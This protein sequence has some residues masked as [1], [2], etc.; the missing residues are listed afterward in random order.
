MHVFVLHCLIPPH[1]HISLS[2]FHVFLFSSFIFLFFYEKAYLLLNFVCTLKT[3]TIIR[4]FH[5]KFPC[6]FCFNLLHVEQA[7]LF[8]LH[9]YRIPMLYFPYSHM[10]P[11]QMH[12][13]E[14]LYTHERHAYT[15]TNSVTKQVN[16]LIF[17][18]TGFQ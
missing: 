15:L 16:H 11:T 2:S 7:H 13:H 12:P 3:S 9:V 14:Y 6:M 1:F 18:K 17:G 10:H 5:F 4:A 8:H